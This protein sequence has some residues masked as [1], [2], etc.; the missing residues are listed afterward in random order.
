MSYALTGLTGHG[1]K[2]ILHHTLSLPAN[3][4][5]SAGHRRKWMKRLEKTGHKFMPGLRWQ[6]VIRLFLKVDGGS[7]Q[8][9]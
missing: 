5:H 3:L 7:A 9:T 1:Y 8:S 6:K 4:Q 2:T